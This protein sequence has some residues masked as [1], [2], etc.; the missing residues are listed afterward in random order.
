MTGESDKQKQKSPHLMSLLQ[1]RCSSAAGM[2]FKCRLVYINKCR[3]DVR[4]IIRSVTRGISSSF[5]F[6]RCSQ[7]LEQASGVHLGKG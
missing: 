4:C 6:E 2:V 5:M 1:T 7:A 3:Y